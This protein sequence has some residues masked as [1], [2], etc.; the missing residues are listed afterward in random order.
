MNGNYKFEVAL[1]LMILMAVLTVSAL[2]DFKTVSRRNA[3]YIKKV[4]A[5][6]KNLKEEFG[7]HEETSDKKF[8][9]LD[10]E[11]DYFI[12]GRWK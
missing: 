9:A 6:V 7:M 2:M 10:G 5:E 4:E 3:E 11:V 8:R 1:L 12:S